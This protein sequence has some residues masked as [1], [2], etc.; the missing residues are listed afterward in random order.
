MKRILIILFLL[1]IATLAICQDTAPSSSFAPGSAYLYS[2]TLQEADQLK[3]KTYI[4]GQVRK[5]GLYIV[6]DDTDLLTLLYLANG[7]TE[8]AKLSKI[9]IV[10]STEEGEEIILVDLK[11]YMETAD[12]NLIPTLQPG[13]TIIV[14]GTVFYAFTRWAD[15]LSNIAIFLSMYLT[16]SN[17]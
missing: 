17:L 15:F 3:I 10:R 16:I 11:D 14:S 7:P 1:S 5:P 2:G 8:D 9:R 12:D 13:D 6:P 4:W